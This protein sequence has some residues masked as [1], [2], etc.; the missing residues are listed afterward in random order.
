LESQIAYKRLPKEVMFN[1]ETCRKILNDGGYELEI[2]N[3]EIKD[4]RD[5]LYR[6]AQ[7]QIDFECVEEN[8]NEVKLIA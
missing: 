8:N 2:S 3:E 5:F 1:I 6:M 7:Y 4:L